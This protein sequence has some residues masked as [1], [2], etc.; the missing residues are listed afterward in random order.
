MQQQWQEALQRRNVQD[1]AVEQQVVQ[2]QKCVHEVH[3]M[4]YEFRPCSQCIHFATK[5]SVLLGW[6]CAMAFR[7]QLYPCVVPAV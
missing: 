6:N 3:T 5:S 7:E 1:A 2:D 4:D